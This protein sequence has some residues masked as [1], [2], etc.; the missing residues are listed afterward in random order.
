ML[1][2]AITEAVLEGNALTPALIWNAGVRAGT[3]QRELTPV[4]L[5]SAL[6]NEGIQDVLDAIARCLP[7]PTERE[8]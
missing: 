7:A 1:S 5:G 4:L 8:S 3:L 2:D 6:K